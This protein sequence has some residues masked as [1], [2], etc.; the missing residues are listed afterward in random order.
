MNT[1]DDVLK[2]FSL[3][4][5]FERAHGI[6]AGPWG[7]LADFEE[8]K[9]FTRKK[10]DDS[11]TLLIVFETRRGSGNFSGWIPSARQAW[12]LGQHFDLYYKLV[13][14]H[15]RKSQKTRGGTGF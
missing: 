7:I 3:A 8:I 2:I 4:T 6:E 9:F 13:D 15:N 10:T 1:V 5:E 11:V 14:G 12:I